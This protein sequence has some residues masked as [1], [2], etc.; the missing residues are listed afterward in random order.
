M[1]KKSDKKFSKIY[2]VFGLIIAAQILA[3]IVIA[4]RAGDMQLLNPAGSIAS[5]QRD[6]MI[7]AAALSLIVIV[8]VFV[9]TFFIVWRYRDG[10]VKAKYRPDWDS[11]KKLEALWWGVPSVIILVLAVV[12]YKTSHSLDPYRPIASENQPITI[13]V[14]AMEWKWLFIYPEQNIATVNY[15]QFPEDTPINFEITSDASMNSFW[16][17]KLGGQIYAMTGMQTKL[18]LIADEPGTYTGSSANLSGEGFSGMK[19]S[20]IAT[21]K[22]KF[23]DWVQQVW[24][25]PDRLTA[26]KYQELSKP[27][28]DEPMHLYNGRDENLYATIIGKYTDPSNTHNSS[29]THGGEH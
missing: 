16:I 24:Q 28:H 10:N 15:I 8:P 6:L 17:P 5:Q 1:A 7:F 29:K 4:A 27:T 3:L 19:F 25:A 18:H 13:Q 9:L 14:V 11:N 20:A 2:T 23:N 26:E 21:S 22:E 12:T